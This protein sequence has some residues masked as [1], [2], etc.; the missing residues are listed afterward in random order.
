MT[1]SRSSCDDRDER[2]RAPGDWTGVR[3][4]GL[5]GEE[6]GAAA[7][8]MAIVLPVFFLLLFGLISFSLM[9]VGYGSA[10]YASR[11]AARYASLH[12]ST[13]LAPASGATIQ[14]YVLPLLIATP[15]SGATVTST[16]A[17]SN[18]VG[19]TINVSVSVTY[20]MLIPFTSTP[21][22]TIISSD[23]RTITR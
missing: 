6:A 11:S 13:S 4:A 1:Q 19:G 21:A 9:L 17:P 10:T 12:S 8:E 18:T 23:K 20:P 14:S 22:V 7:L 15:T 16:Y 3:W 5:A 2:S